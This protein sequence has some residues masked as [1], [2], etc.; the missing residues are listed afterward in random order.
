M[1]A[2]L[3]RSRHPARA[4][5]QA[6]GGTSEAELPAL[7]ELEQRGRANGLVGMRRLVGEEIAE[8]EPHAS[9][10]AALHVAETGIVDYTRVT[11]TLGRLVR[12]AGRPSRRMPAS[13][14]SNAQRQRRARNCPRTVHCRALINC[15]GLQSDR[16]ARLCGV[17]PGLRIVPFRG[18]YY[19]LVP[20]AALPRAQPAL[21]GAGPEFPFLG[22][23]FTR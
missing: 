5:R 13:A 14:R 20:S 6:R 16:I 2:F 11:E 15:G 18:D 23:H 4:L 12:E 22:V 8:H 1:Y 19:E 17:D 21:P 3:P 9:G 10:V 7:A